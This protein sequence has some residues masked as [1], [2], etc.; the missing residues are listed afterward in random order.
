MD[1]NLY[2]FFKVQTAVEDAMAGY[3]E[4]YEEKKKATIQSGLC[5]D[6]FIKKSEPTTE[7]PTNSLPS[8]SHDV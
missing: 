7:D 6:R 8:T 1:S 2:R 3:R 5:L 4:I